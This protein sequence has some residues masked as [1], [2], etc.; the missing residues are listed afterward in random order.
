[1]VYESNTRESL[2]A[3]LLESDVGYFETGATIEQ[4]KGA[5]VAHTPGLENLAAG[6]VV[7]RIDPRVIPSD[8]VGWI[9]D[10]ERKLLDWG[11]EH[12]RFYL[13][14]KAPEL[15]AALAEKG[16]QSR[17]ELVVMR[18]ATP[19]TGNS[20]RVSL[21]LIE[22]QADWQQKQI[23]HKEIEVGPDGHPA[24]ADLWVAMERQKCEAGYMRP[25]LIL[26]DGAVVG[27]ANGAPWKGVLRLKNVAIVP[28]FR[29]RGIGSVAVGLLADLSV[30]DGK[31]AA[32]AFVFA[33][34]PFVK[35]YTGAGFDVVARQTE[36][37]RELPVPTRH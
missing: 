2:I 27:A 16:Y 14:E 10:V 23:L 11:I 28:E 30:A 25:Y 7:Q 6:S 19:I 15:E 20:E 13:Q 35:M 1:M 26:A 36:W 4:L 22:T 18:P 24:P 31:Q 5:T 33:D 3:D 34:E 12:A 32:G 8:V 37:A 17:D 29:L 9:E 21:R